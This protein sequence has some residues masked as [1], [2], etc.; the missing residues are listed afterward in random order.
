MTQP[1]GDKENGEVKEITD[2]LNRIEQQLR[3][4][5]DI[6]KE[7]QDY[8]KIKQ[9][10]TK[11]Y[12]TN[13]AMLA[14]GITLFALIATFWGQ[15]SIYIDDEGIDR[16]M[17]EFY[18]ALASMTMYGLLGI[19]SEVHHNIFENDILKPYNDLSTKQNIRSALSSSYWLQYYREAIHKAPLLAIRSLISFAAAILLIVI[20]ID[21]I[22]YL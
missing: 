4:L 15:F 17:L 19:L 16:L 13:T 6:E 10:R 18:I 11:W 12:T 9:A 1:T 5:V 3:D 8:E 7:K 20:I 14:I 2:K 22:L 21:L